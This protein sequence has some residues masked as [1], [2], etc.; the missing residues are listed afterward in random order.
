MTRAAIEEYRKL[1]AR[2]KKSLLPRNKEDLKKTSAFIVYRMPE[3]RV[4]SQEYM[5]IIVNNR[6]QD[7]GEYIETEIVQTE[8]NLINQFEHEQVY[9]SR[10]FNHYEEPCQ[11]DHLQTD[12]N[13]GSLETGQT[14]NEQ[15]EANNDVIQLTQELFGDTSL[16]ENSPSLKD[17]NNISLD[18]VDQ[19][20]SD[21][22][23]VEIF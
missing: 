19:Q 10:R 23:K 18:K 5:S 8:S 11:E 15:R 7:E 21:D 17:P 1:K 9:V 13:F 22:M 4:A 20:G 2:K 16:V 3:N 14:E 12:R 6:I